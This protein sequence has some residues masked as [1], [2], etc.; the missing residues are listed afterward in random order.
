MKKTKIWVLLLLLVVFM[1]GI[2]AEIYA[3]TATT[4]P[5]VHIRKVDEQVV[6]YTIYRGSY[7]QMS[8]AIGELYALAGRK[9]IIPRGPM[10]YAYL[11]NPKYVS[12]QHLLT[13]IRIPVGKEALKSAG[14]LGKMTDVKKLPARQVAVAVKPQGLADPSPIYAQLYAWTYQNGYMAIGGCCEKFLSHSMQGNYAQMKSEIMVPVIKID[15][16]SVK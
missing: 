6:L 10:T 8:R 3:K 12:S 4:K 1:V 7:H 14:T 11:N 2:A 9:G 5:A 13:E 16:K 15:I